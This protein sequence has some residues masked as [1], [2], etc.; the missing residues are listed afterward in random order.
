MLYDI[1]LMD[2]ARHRA[3]TGVSNG[4]ILENLEA[5]A[6]T[7]VNIWVRIPIIPGVNDDDANLAATAA[8]LRPLAGIT[9]VDLLPYHPTGAPKFARFGLDYALRGTA[10]PATAR[11]EALAARI[12]AEGLTTTIGGHA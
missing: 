6:A 5:L 7:H 11:L 2:D 10:A 3:A 4:I 12:R 9:R 8:F 1:K